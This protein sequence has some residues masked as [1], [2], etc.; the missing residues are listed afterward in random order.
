MTELSTSL[1]VL[2]LEYFA[3]GCFWE[4]A[5]FL[6]DTPASGWSLTRT[7][8]TE[9]RVLNTAAA[10]EVNLTRVPLDEDI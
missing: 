10:G 3:G 5:V 7:V 6:K 1:K 9:T 8:P 4:E 2:G